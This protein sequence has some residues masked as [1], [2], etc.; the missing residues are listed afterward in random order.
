M[1]RLMLMIALIAAIAISAGAAQVPVYV[2]HRGN[3]EAAIDRIA[4][5]GTVLLKGDIWVIRIWSS[6]G[7]IDYVPM[8]LP[9]Q[10]Q[11]AGTLV[12][13]TGYTKVLSDTNRWAGIP[14]ILTN[15]KPAR[16]Y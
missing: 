13:F 8:N 14:L 15:I 7:I 3:P 12:N 9:A 2:V 1:K 11:F 4:G 16:G 5:N 10:Y 6:E